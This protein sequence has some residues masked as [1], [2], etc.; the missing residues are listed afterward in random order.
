MIEWPS[1][2]EMAAS[3]DLS[4]SKGLPCARPL[5]QEKECPSVASYCSWNFLGRSQLHSYF[6][7]ILVFL[8]E[9]DSS[10]MLYGMLLDTKPVH[11][12]VPVSWFKADSWIQHV[13]PV[14]ARWTPEV[15]VAQSP[16]L[17][18]AASDVALV[19]HPSSFLVDAWKYSKWWK[20]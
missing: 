19:D 13:F 6:Y 1:L 3:L 9:L 2:A 17:F 20:P 14:V 15:V 10:E 4:P 18:E 7:Q 5:W 12:T 11:L 16:V 8:I